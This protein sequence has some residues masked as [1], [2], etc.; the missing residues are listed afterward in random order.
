MMVRSVRIHSYMLCPLGSISCVI[1][2]A[3][4]LGKEE[5]SRDGGLDATES[6]VGDNASNQSARGRA[7]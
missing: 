5:L 2:V 4:P 6:D 7:P 1:S 3:T